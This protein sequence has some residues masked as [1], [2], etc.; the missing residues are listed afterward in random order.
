VTDSPLLA[1]SAKR[2]EVPGD[3]F[4]E[5]APAVEGS[6]TDDDPDESA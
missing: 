6:G 4:G 3:D 2:S 5:F 1:A